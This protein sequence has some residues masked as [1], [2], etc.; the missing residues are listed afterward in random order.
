VSGDALER[1]AAVAGERPVD[2]LRQLARPLAGMRIV[3]VNSTRVGGGVAEI[4]TK[5]TPLMRALDIDVDW[6]VV[7]GEEAYYRTTK[8]MH[9]AL[10]GDPLDIPQRLLDLYL[11]TARHNAEEL[12]HSVTDADVVM[13]HDPQ[14]A[15]LRSLL[16]E[17]RGVWIW[18]CHIDLSRPH[19]PVWRFLRPYVEAHDASIFSLADF[20]R[21]LPHPQFLIPPSIDPLSEKNVELPASE[22]QRVLVDHGIDPAR[23]MVV[24]VSR[25]DRFKD[26]VG[27]IHAYHLAKRFSPGLQLV[28]AGGTATDDP[29]GAEVLD[30]VRTASEEDPD[31]HVLLLP[32]D[33]HRIINALQRGADI[34]LQKSLREGFGLTV[35]E[36]MWKG[37]PVIGGRAG[38]IRLQIRDGFNGYLVSTPE[39]AAFRIRELLQDAGFRRTMGANAREHA[40]SNFLLTRL[41]REHL[42]VVHALTRNGDT[43]I[44]LTGDA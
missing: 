35:T 6:E 33:A 44:D 41:L 20:T 40:R 10:Q 25:F 7:T 16:P 3:H 9:N 11:E 19:R 31:I 23:P 12:R 24:Q 15:P 14:P 18:R 21:R 38:G 17:A 43:R 28:L 37:K 27:V 32:P 34:V 42:T 13:I 22:V 2:Q 36:G 30:E 1:Y 5:L 39:G 8:A 4:L 26:P 29:E